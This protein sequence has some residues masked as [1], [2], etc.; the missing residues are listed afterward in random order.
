MSPIITVLLSVHNGM[1]HLAAAVESILGQTFR[2]FEF[3]ILD[4]A[5]SDG[6]ADYLRSLTDERIRIVTLAENI[7]LTAALN[8]GL[9]EA[10]GEFIARQDADDISAAG[11][12][13]SQV[14]YLR[15]HPDC[16]LV[17][18]Q[19]RL[20]DQRGRSLGKKDFPLRHEA[21][22]FG[23]L[24][25]NM[26]AHSAVL[27]R[28]ATVEAIGGYDEAWRSS[29]DYELWSRLAGQGQLANLPE[30]LVT[31]RVLDS[32]ITR[33]H[34]RGDLIRRA[35]A[36]H[37]RRVF[38]RDATAADLDLIALFRSRVVPERL[39][40]FDALVDELAADYEDLLPGIGGNGDFRRL[41]AMVHERVGYNLLTLS[42]RSAFRE[43]WRALQAWP[44]AIISMPW[45]RIV[46][47]GIVGDH[48]RRL[49]EKFAR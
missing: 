47:L 26:L 28:C 35:Q 23:H 19:A 6:T 43:F 2:D 5:S 44:P 16:V 45:P 32:S 42:R 37:F 9:R 36:A 25:D 34:K 30:R 12:L 3:L 18:A 20:L 49:Y 15:A 48:A 17:G 10:R 24:F 38:G 1:P 14:S 7:G 29:Q 33:T 4:D 27:Y 22:V 13:E 46:A 31:L 39:R 8:R 40:E 21:I 11:R 41:I